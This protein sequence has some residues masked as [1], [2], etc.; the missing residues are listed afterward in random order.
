MLLCAAVIEWAWLHTCVG[1]ERAAQVTLPGSSALWPLA[2][3]FGV[4]VEWVLG[5]LPLG[6][7]INTTW[8]LKASA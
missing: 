4:T 6:L 2:E 5:Y 1:A 7:S 8:V 3:K